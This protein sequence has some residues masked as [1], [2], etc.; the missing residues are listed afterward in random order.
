MSR[1]IAVFTSY[2]HQRHGDL[3]SAIC[4]VKSIL[5]VESETTFEW[6]I[7]RDISGFD[8][9]LE[10]FKAT[11]LGVFG[12]RVNLTILN[13]DDYQH[14]TIQEH[15]V[16]DNQTQQALST[17]EL[18]IRSDKNWGLSPQWYGW[19][20]IHRQLNTPPVSTILTTCDLFAVIGNNHRMVYSDHQLLHSFNKKMIL[21]PEYDLNHVNNCTWGFQNTE[22]VRT[23]FEGAGVYVDEMVQAN[24]N[25][26]DCSPRDANFLL[27][28][29]AN[30]REQYKQQHRLF[31]GYFF[32]NEKLSPQSTTVK[33]VSWIN[34][35]I[36]LA[37]DMGEK[38]KIDL[39]IPGFKNPAQ[40]QNIYQQA[41]TDL[42]LSYKNLLGSVSYDAKQ[43]DG[44][45]N[46]IQLEYNDS[47]WQIR[48]INP[49]RLE[50]KT[51]QALLTDS[52]P[53]VGLTGDASWIEG[54][55][56]GKLVCYQ[57]V[58]WKRIFFDAFMGLLYN[59]MPDSHLFTF[60]A[61]QCMGKDPDNLFN[62]MR[63]LYQN[64]LPELQQDA[65]RIATCIAEEKNLS[66][67]LRSTFFAPSSGIGGSLQE[68][69]KF[70][71]TP[72]LPFASL[73]CSQ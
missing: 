22:L 3:V 68:G 34:Q 58:N 25:L 20:D 65:A 60:Y 1:K 37:I 62:Q 69:T 39:V 36:R 57:I 9:D 55:I 40:L 72:L 63:E 56:K 8:R 50:R 59:K 71:S 66:L 30:N 41:L 73:G 19:N 48:L 15:Q 18:T 11:E 31:Y 44:S 12:S 28:L 51:V 43:P 4:F 23:G 52:D 54:L 67:Y 38:Y 46:S 14:V 70:P 42:P 17:D 6:I 10:V 2:M 61:L 33:I 35:S 32:D 49:Q 27:H 53:W 26:E 24:N 45:F 21:I 47:P 7:K 5:A 64:H 29:T 13:S 16:I